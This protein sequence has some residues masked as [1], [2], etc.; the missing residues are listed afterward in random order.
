MGGHGGTASDAVAPAHQPPIKSRG[1]IWHLGALWKR[2]KLEGAQEERALEDAVEE[3]VMEGALEERAQLSALEGLALERALGT[4]LESAPPSGVALPV[5]GGLGRDADGSVEFPA[6]GGL[7]EATDDGGLVLAWGRTLSRHQRIPSLHF[8]P[9]VSGRSMGRWE[10][11]LCQFPRWG[12]HRVLS[13]WRAC[14][15]HRNTRQR[16]DLGEQG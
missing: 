11:A 10:F 2:R 16:G 7:E 4:L 12:R 6:D 15:T 3:R 13:P 9:V 5:D 8:S 1:S 14:R